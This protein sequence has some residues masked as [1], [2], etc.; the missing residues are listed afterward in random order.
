[1]STLLY[2]GSEPTLIFLNKFFHESIYI[3]AWFESPK[4]LQLTNFEIM[5]NLQ[6]TIF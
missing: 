4:Y 1:M 6:Q 2:M 5:R 3:K